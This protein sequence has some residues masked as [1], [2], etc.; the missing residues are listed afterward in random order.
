MHLQM[1][2][3]FFIT[4]IVDSSQLD[5]VLYQTCP[6]L[7]RRLLHFHRKRKQQRE[8]KHAFDDDREMSEVWM[9]LL[10]LLDQIR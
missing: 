3:L 6:D 9:E 10:A 1:R 8:S 2:Y 5:A 4:K 7:M